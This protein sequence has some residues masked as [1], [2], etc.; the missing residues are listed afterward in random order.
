MTREQ[1]IHIWH[2]IRLKKTTDS[3]NT[4]LSFLRVRKEIPYDFNKGWHNESCIEVANFLR[5]VADALEEK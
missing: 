5:Q 3:I 4:I 1:A 2:S